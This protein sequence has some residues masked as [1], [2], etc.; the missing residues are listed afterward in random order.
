MKRYGKEQLD[1]VLLDGPPG[2][3]KTTTLVHTIL[4]ITARHPTASVLVCAPSN[5]ACN[6]IA[7]RL[8]A[9]VDPGMCLVQRVLAYQRDPSTLPASLRSFV[10][11]PDGVNVPTPGARVVIC[12]LMCSVKLWEM[13]MGEGS[14]DLIILDE[15]GYATE[16]ELMIPLRLKGSKCDV[17]F[18]GDPRQLGPI[19]YSSVAKRHMYDVPV[20]E[21]YAFPTRVQLEKSYR[22]HHA[23]FDLYSSIFYSDAKLQCNVG[24]D[25]NWAAEWEGLPNMGHPVAFFHCGHME[26]RPNDSPSIENEGEAIAITYCVESVMRQFP[27]IKPQ[28][29]GIITP[30]AAQRRLIRAKLWG[31]KTRNLSQIMCGTVEQFQGQE[32]DVIF[33]STVRSTS[34]LNRDIRHH[35]GFMAQPKRINVTISRA[36]CLLVIIGNGSLLQC[37]PTWLKVLTQ[38]DMHGGCNPSL[39]LSPPLTKE[40]GVPT[41]SAEEAMVD[42][43]EV[44]A[45]ILL[46]A[47]QKD[48]T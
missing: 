7:E 21:R 22:C 45:N 31:S 17:V 40:V 27:S 36:K 25:C 30:Y 29:V 41:S 15:A 11:R 4:K 28:N 1:A 47:G 34:T 18:A 12:T 43:L 23:I 5:D 14:F 46:D 24:T 44:E 42:G 38:I 20:I 9:K 13:G 3:G 6:V 2:T 48:N 33:V 26:N 19:V 39:G 8:A 16:V 32:R 37:D 35:L 10:V